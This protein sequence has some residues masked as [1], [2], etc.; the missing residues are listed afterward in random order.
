MLPRFTPSDGQLRPSNSATVEHAL[1]VIDR[2]AGGVE[3]LAETGVQLTPL[4]TMSLREGAP[5]PHRP[6]DA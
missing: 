6:P 5:H 2:E 3:N 1:C 4:F